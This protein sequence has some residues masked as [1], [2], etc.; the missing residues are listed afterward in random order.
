VKPAPFAYW[1]P[2]DLESALAF[3]AE[4]AEDSSLLAGGQSLMP[5]LNMRLVRPEY[6]VDLNGVSELGRVQ[7][8]NGA[9][10]VGALCRQDALLRSSV[11]RE[12][13]PLLAK[14]LPHVGHTAIRYRGTLGGSLAHA[15]PAA[16]LPA[17]AVAADAEIT[18]QSSSGE[19]TI[20]AGDFFRT[21]LTT[22]IEP[23][24][25][26][27]EVRVPLRPAGHTGTAVIELARRHG[28]FALVGVAVEL[29]LSA[30]TIGTARICAFGVDQVPRRLGDVESLLV[31]ESPGEELLAQA[32]ATAA[33]A[34][35]PTSDMHASAEYRRRMCGVLAGRALASAIADAGGRRS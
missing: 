18:L 20:P 2:H 25:I 7:R 35:E 31:G 21:H 19:R 11:V 14:A 28:D 32:A 5:L 29:T 9:L 33:R 8:E 15:D 16:E 34:V 1:D 22:A 26:L 27:T 3:L 23:G 12:A 30:G 24:E 17:V 4:H 13:C 6:L 10:R